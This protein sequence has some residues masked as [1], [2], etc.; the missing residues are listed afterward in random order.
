[1]S[2][3]RKIKR[4]ESK[5]TR[6]L[7]E[8]FLDFSTFV[9]WHSGSYEGLFF[10]D[11][12]VDDKFIECDNAWRRFVNN[13]R[14]NP[15]R[16]VDFAVYAFEEKA[17]SFLAILRKQAWKKYMIG[18]MPERYGVDTTFDE[19]EDYYEEGIE[20]NEAG[21]RMVMDIATVRPN[22]GEMPP[23]VPPNGGKT[24]RNIRQNMD[25]T[26]TIVTCI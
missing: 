19:L 14:R 8:L 23:S 16:K 9:N 7:N 20:A 18:F 13:N 15:K 6:L 1:M 25:S 21:V 26:P 3:F 10:V 12:E 2:H 4:Q 5:G 11:P 24:G 22:A 17:E